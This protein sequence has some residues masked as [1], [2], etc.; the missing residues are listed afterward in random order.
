MNKKKAHILTLIIVFSFIPGFLSQTFNLELSSEK[1]LE[2][3]FLSQISFKKKHGDST[4]IYNELTKI[5]KLIKLNGYFLS[6]LDSI[7]LKRKKY[8]AHFNLNEKI[9]SVSLK[10]KNLP[11][12]ISR[13]FN[14]LNNNLKIPIEKLEGVINKISKELE[15]KGDSFSKIKLQNITIKNRTL[16]A[17]INY[18]KTKERKVNKLLFKGY[19]NFPNSFIKNYFDINNNTTFTKNKLTEISKLSQ[20]LDFAS[21]IKSPEALFTKDSTYIYVYLRK[22]KV[23]SFDGLI[24]FSSQENGKLQFN[25]YLDLKLK[26]I[27]NTGESLNLL[28]NSYEE[29]RQELSITSKKP[30]IF[31]TKLSTELNFSIYK[32]DST[33]LNTKFSSHLQYQIRNN[34]TLFLSFSSENSEKLIKTTSNKIETYKSSFFGLGFQY[35]IPKNDIFRN[36]AF[37]LNITPSFG[38]RKSDNTSIN[39]VKLES[40]ISYLLDLNKRNS[41]YL[42][43]KTGLLNSESYL[44]N[45][46]F[47]IGGW[48]TIRGFDKQSIFVKSYILQNIEYR[49]LTSENSFIYS[50]TDLALISTTNNNEKLIGL[51]LGYL[52][53][54][55]NS[56]INISTII[57]TN[58]KNSLN[59]KNTQL[60]I[61]WTN[62]F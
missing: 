39:Q 35:S 26:N 32:Q 23:N 49:Y 9:D 47:R 24:N 1:K 48:N 54:S 60:L 12:I 62:F 29:K 25:G 44:E 6:S 53:N 2:K 41:M 19:N 20:N 55:K 8:S 58:T 3:K 28:W 15:D 61:K 34:T 38:K 17:E 27:L 59:T 52:F 51:G 5:H 45:E 22:N 33:F 10:H 37:Y 50:V 36:D 56:Q 42:K 46:L 31:N 13:N 18:K 21:E 43:N 57:G 7:T 40:T 16:F 14:F 30:Y 4:S 11:P